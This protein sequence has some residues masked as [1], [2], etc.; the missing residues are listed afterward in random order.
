MKFKRTMAALLAAAMMISFSACKAEPNDDEEEVTAESDEAESLSTRLAF[1]DSSASTIMSELTTIL[2]RMDAEKSGMKMSSTSLIT[3]TVEDGVWKVTNGTPDSFRSNM[4]TWNG[5]GSSDSG[6]EDGAED[7]MAAQLAD[8]MPN[9]K[10]AG[11]SAWFESG[12]CLAVSF[13]V[14]S[15]TPDSQVTGNMGEGG[16]LETEFEWD[17]KVEGV[18]TDGNVV[19]TSPKLRME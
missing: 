11:I 6:S 14:D 8:R 3:I 7:F 13:T 17:G 2:T 16:W 9:V 18:S 5:S 12:S 19:G 4:Y 15:S 1:A 10:S